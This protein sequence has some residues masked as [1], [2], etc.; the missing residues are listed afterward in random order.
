MAR[1]AEIEAAEPELCARAR[2]RFD[3]HVHK[4]I[5]TL[6][7]DGS[8]R[9]SGI[10]TIFAEGDVWVGSMRDAVKAQDLQR[11]PRYALHSGSDDPP[12]WHGDARLAGT[13]EEVVDQ[14]VLDS[15]MAAASPEAHD[16]EHRIEEMHLFRL[17]IEELVW[18]GLDEARERLIVDSWHPDRGRRR[19]ER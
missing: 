17:E 6:R 3:A 1:W 10:E 18:I 2:A 13:A 14:D 8:P 16:A 4:T 7:R 11:D 5:A 15:V 19:L 12:D 9:I